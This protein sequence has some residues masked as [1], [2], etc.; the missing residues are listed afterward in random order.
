MLN[1][2][3]IGMRLS[4]GFGVAVIVL[5]VIGVTNL[6]NL[7]KLDSNVSDLVNDKFPKTIWAN[8]IRDNIN[9]NSRAIRNLF[10][11]TDTRE[12]DKEFTRLSV[13]K[14]KVDA[15]VDSLQR[16]IKTEKGKKLINRIEE[17]RKGNYY[18]ARN[19]MLD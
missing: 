17:I 6:I 10:L 12:I 1:N 15:L 8:E 9:D 19:K 3:K 4:L 16:L 5:L 14:E 11:L 13:A 18:N 7:G 2:I